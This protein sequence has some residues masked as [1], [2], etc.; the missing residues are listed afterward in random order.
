MHDR[1]DVS[2]L[3]QMEMRNLIEDFAAAADA[4]AAVR[5]MVEVS[6]ASAL[7]GVDADRSG[8]AGARARRPAR[9]VARTRG[10]SPRDGARRG[11]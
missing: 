11:G 10:A 9:R 1:H 4:L 2:A 5:Q 6:G 3:W 8:G 7:A